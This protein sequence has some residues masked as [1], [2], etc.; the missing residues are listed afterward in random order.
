MIDMTEIRPH[1]GAKPAI[2]NGVIGI[3]ADADGL[4][5]DD[6]GNKATGIGAVMRT[7]P[8]NEKGSHGKS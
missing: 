5:I 2:G 4:A 7:G 1:L 6:F 8:A 3:G